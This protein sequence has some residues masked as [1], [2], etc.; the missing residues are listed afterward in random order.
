ML[1]ALSEAE[2]QASGTLESGWEHAGNHLQKK[3]FFETYM[4]GI[5]FAEGLAIEAEAM[6]HH[7]EM[8]IKYL[9]VI[10]CLSTYSVGAVT[11]RDTDLAKRADR[12]ASL[13][14]SG[15]K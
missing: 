14:A 11:Y 13:M 2:I 15:G 7:P 6:D 12:V 9:E 1:H 3:Y 5:R 10:V 8:L 4:D